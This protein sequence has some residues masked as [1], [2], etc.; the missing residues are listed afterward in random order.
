MD[1]KRVL[2]PD[3]LMAK[4]M[5]G[6]EHRPQQIEAALAIDRSLTSRRHCMV[7]AGTGVG[8]SMAYLL[9]VIDHVVNGKRVVV[10]THTIYLQSQLIA[11]DIPFLRQILP[12]HKFRVALVK[13][14]SNYAC[15]NNFDME[16]GQLSLYADPNLD[17]I[18]EWLNETETGDLSE[19][20]FQFSAW[21]DICSDQDTCH[22]QDCK[23]F[24]KCFYYKMRKTASEADIIVTNHSLFF[25]DLA[26]R[27]SNPKA[28][29]LP[30]YDAVVFDEAHHLEDIAT[31]VFGVE[32]TS[33]SMPALLSKVKRLKGTGVDPMRLQNIEDL[34]TELLEMFSGNPKQEFFFDDVYGR[35]QKDRIENTASTLCNALD[36]LN[37]EMLDLDTE[38]RPELKERIDGLRRICGRLKDEIMLLF[39]GP[40]EGHFKW[41]ERVNSG[42]YTN[43]FLRYS[44]LSVSDILPDSLWS[45]VSSAILTSA[46]ITGS[47][48]FS[49][50]KSRLGLA[51]CDELI[52]DSPFDFQKQCL[53]YV[54]RH[55]EF[56]SDNSAYA[57]KISDEIEGLVL[58]SGG[59]AF[60]L[61]TSYRMMHA[62]Y[63][64]LFGRLPYVLM[65]QGDMAN[66]ELIQE[67]LK[68]ENACLFGVHSFW[69]GVDIRGEALSCV[70]I[71]KLPFASPDSPV[72][73]ARADAVTASGGNGFTE[74]AIPQAQ[75]RL[76]QG[77]GRL[78]RTKND[79]G[80]VAIL[81]SRLVK[82]FYGREFL[83]FLPQCPVT[84][85][86]DDVRA[87]YNGKPSGIR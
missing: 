59:R 18:K 7:E 17:R 4:N 54:P 37:R 43:C 65:K 60:L 28:G 77:F 1:I 63:D 39:F 68:Q 14:R 40:N 80:V 61:F 24:D 57:D 16:L 35:G 67:F 71:D 46:T 79:K 45:Q 53:L 58:A 56:P 32:Y 55:L 31:K 8:K 75:T 26:I 20:N 66:E 6:Y 52:E 21:S 83:K 81:D 47:G 76:K 78:I 69:E 50:L 2:G 64:R 49:Y 72:N 44:P 30:E 34:N 85:K 13:G 12:W 87:F 23:W 15:L 33:F 84:F 48:G 25:S 70:V 74:Y 22:H 73:K 27:G 10:S 19:L 36:G 5:P 41:G 82:K 42:R 11:K 62:V 3:G 86:I 38:G 9:P 51:D 29:I